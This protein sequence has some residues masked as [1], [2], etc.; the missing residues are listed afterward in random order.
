MVL[1]SDAD[2]RS[3]LSDENATL[4]TG[5]DSAL[6]VDDSDAE[7]CPSQDVSGGR[8]IAN[9]TEGRNIFAG[10]STRSNESGAAVIGDGV[11]GGSRAYGSSMH[12]EFQHLNLNGHIAFGTP[13]G[14]VLQGDNTLTDTHRLCRKYDNQPAPTT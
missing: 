11:A 13:T 14:S 1:S 3:L 6:E 8:A 10:D 4:L 9:P 7:I 2:A 12:N 5:I